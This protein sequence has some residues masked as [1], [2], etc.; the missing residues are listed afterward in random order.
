[1]SLFKIIDVQADSRSL[2]FGE[3]AIPQGQR[4]Y[5]SLSVNS[6]FFLNDPLRYGL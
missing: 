2:L 4:S 5:A 1:M 6:I 3:G